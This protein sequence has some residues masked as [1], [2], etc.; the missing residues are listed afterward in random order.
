MAW[1]NVAIDSQEDYKYV[2][3]GN[4]LGQIVK[5]HRNSKTTQH[6][7]ELKP[8]ILLTV[9]CRFSGHFPRKQTELKETLLSLAPQPG[10]H[11]TIETREKESTELFKRWLFARVSI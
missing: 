10:I 4:A 1:A 2:G 6:G 11:I 9:C 8:I 5:R 3:L 7:P